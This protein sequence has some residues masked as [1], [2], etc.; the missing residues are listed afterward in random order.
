MTCETW[1]HAESAI[2]FSG[3]QRVRSTFFGQEARA[4]QQMLLLQKNAGFPGV[5]RIFRPIVSIYR[6]PG[7]PR[8]IL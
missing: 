1:L 3:C 7:T 8:R 5:F 4:S 2:A 6:K